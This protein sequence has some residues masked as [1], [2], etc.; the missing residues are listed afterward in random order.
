MFNANEFLLYFNYNCLL[1]Y[2]K[3]TED[4][5]FVVGLHIS[6]IKILNYETSF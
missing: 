5:K 1:T 6:N 2:E 3:Y 4:D